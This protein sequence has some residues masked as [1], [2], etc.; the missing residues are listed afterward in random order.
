MSPGCSGAAG[1]RD[2]ERQDPAGH[3]E[4]DAWMGGGGEFK[5]HAESRGHPWRR[6]W[7]SGQHVGRGGQGT[8]SPAGL[9]WYS[10]SG[11]HPQRHGGQLCF[12]WGRA[13]GRVWHGL[14]LRWATSQQGDLVLVLNLSEPQRL[15]PYIGI[16]RTCP[17]VP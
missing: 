2:M 5:G 1:P 14:D 17:G 10:C 4:G 13:I 6:R 8:G 11:L 7:R 16:M 9:S 3:D 12:P 15:H